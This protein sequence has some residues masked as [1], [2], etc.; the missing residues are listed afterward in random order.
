MFGAAQAAPKK[1]VSCR[2]FRKK[3][4]LKAG[5][6]QWKDVPG[7]STRLPTPG[8]R[9]GHDRGHGEHALQ[10]EQHQQRHHR[11]AAQQPRGRRGASLA[12]GDGGRV[13]PLAPFVLCPLL[14]SGEVRVLC[15]LWLGGGAG[16]A[17]GDVSWEL[18]LNS[19]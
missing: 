2:F 13:V 8:G 10:D 11:V 4:Q 17:R 9:R 15:V 19:V 6:A 1:K 3:E 14:H 12:A 16:D 18:L 5:V 7:S